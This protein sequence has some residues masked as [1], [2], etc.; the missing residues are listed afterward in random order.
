VNPNS[1]IKTMEDL[2]GKSVVPIESTDGRYVAFRDWQK[3]HPN[4]KIKMEASSTQPTFTDMIQQVHDGTYDAVY[5]SK[6]QFDGVKDSLGYPMKVTDA[7]DGRDTVF[8]LNKKN[9]DAQ[10]QVNKSIEA[11][12]KDGTL[13]GLTKKWFK[14]DN[15]ALAEKLGIADN[16]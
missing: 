13:A 9:Q 12:T 5:L 10:Q 1:K 6:D 2:N 3:K 4:V 8:L 14:Q 7:V 16:G 11:L 15:F